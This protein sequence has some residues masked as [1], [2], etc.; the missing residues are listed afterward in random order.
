[1]SRKERCSTSPSLNPASSSCTARAA[2]SAAGLLLLPRR[3]ASARLVVAAQRLAHRAMNRAGRPIVCPGH[4]PLK[5]PAATRASAFGLGSMPLRL[6]SSLAS[7]RALIALLRSHVWLSLEPVAPAAPTLQRG[8]AGPQKSRGRITT[9]IRIFLCALHGWDGS[10]TQTPG[11]MSMV[12]T[13]SSPPPL[14]QPPTRAAKN[15]RRACPT[16]E[17]K[18]FIYALKICA[19]TMAVVETPGGGR[20]SC[21]G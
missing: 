10:R 9:H 13:P 5:I 12:G 1:M 3:L 8:I 11:I 20:P 6:K 18:S 2:A 21:H 15:P 19:S 7:A 17:K 16:T 4:L 14:S